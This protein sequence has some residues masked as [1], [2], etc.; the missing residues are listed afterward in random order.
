[1]GSVG[2]PAAGCERRR[3][4]RRALL[5]GHGAG[6]GI[7][8]Q[9][10]GQDL[11]ADVPPVVKD[12]P[13]DEFLPVFERLHLVKEQVAQAI[14]DKGAVVKVKALRLVGLAAAD[15]GRARLGQRVKVDPLLPRGLVGG[16]LQVLQGDDRDDAPLAQL[17]DLRAELGRSSVA[18]SERGPAGLQPTKPKVCTPWVSVSTVCASARFQPPP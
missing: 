1:M 10:R 11:G 16:I 2:A 18:Q 13:V 14:V 7:V 17:A 4:E 5:G 3:Q 9:H 15:E 8:L 12:V 6:P